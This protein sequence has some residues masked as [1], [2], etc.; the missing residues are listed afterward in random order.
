MNK[1]L[2]NLENSKI[3]EIAK[4]TLIK[5]EIK[6]IKLREIY[7]KLEIKK[8]FLD[9]IKKTNFRHL[10]IYTIQEFDKYF[11]NRNISPNYAEE[12][13]TTEILWNQLIYR[14]FIKNVKVDKEKIIENIKTKIIHSTNISFWKFYLQWVIMKI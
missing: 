3:I 5:Q 4:K 14:Q 13:I 11:L 9:N 1:D 8:E 12:I 10:N 7:K 6:K 2:N